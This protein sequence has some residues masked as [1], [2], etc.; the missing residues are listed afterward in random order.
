LGLEDALPL[1]T[2]RKVLGIVPEAVVDSELAR[3]ESQHGVVASN[4]LKEL[5]GTW[6]LPEI[7]VVC[8]SGKGVEWARH[9]DLYVLAAHLKR[10]PILVQEAHHSIIKQRPAL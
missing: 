5:G 9:L 1:H 6:I 8:Q 7:E 10:T 4:V 3:H 2:Y